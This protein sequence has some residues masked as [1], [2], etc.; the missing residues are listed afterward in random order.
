VE[1]RDVLAVGAAMAE[2]G[3]D[4]AHAAHCGGAADD[5]GRVL[6]I[7]AGEAALD[8]DVVAEAG[9]HGRHRDPAAAERHADAAH[10]TVIYWAP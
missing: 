7:R 10:S 4:T 2:H 6:E 1:G 9:G 3:T 5:R 8:G